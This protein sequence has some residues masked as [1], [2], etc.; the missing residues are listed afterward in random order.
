MLYTFMV[1]SKK[2]VNFVG[3]YDKEEN[4]FVSEGYIIS[5]KSSPDVKKYS[6]TYI[7]DEIEVL[8]INEP[9]IKKFKNNISNSKKEAYLAYLAYKKT[10][11]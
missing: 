8:T 1:K 7:N 5:E 2:C 4:L 11:R 10:K 3:K 6:I 9:I